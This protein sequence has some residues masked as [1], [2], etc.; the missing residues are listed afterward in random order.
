MKEKGIGQSSAVK[1]KQS[2]L[3]KKLGFIG[4]SAECFVISTKNASIGTLNHGLSF[5]MSDM[6]K[7]A[8][9]TMRD[10]RTVHIHVPEAVS[11]LDRVNLVRNRSMNIL[12]GV[13]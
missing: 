6:K 12:N 3:K 10:T 13:S 2:S 7:I 11:K 5:P 8:S 9:D 1:I 4:Q